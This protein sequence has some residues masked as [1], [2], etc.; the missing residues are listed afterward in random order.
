M[1]HKG[2]KKKGPDMLDTSN[3]PDKA[4]QFDLLALLEAGA[5]FGHQKAKWSPK[6]AQFIY[7]EKDGVHIFDLEK[8]A[9]Q[10]RTA[11]NLAYQMGKQ[12]KVMVIVGT[13]RQAQEIVR[14]VATANKVM[15]ITSRWLGGLLTNWEQVKGSIKRMNEI[16]TGLA[17][18]A[19]KGYTKYEKVQLE[20]EMNRLNRF[21]GGIKDLKGKPDCIF[22]IDPKREKNA[23]KEANIMGVPVIAMIDSNADPDLVD[24]PIP[25]NDDAIKSIEM[26]VT[27]VVAGYEAGKK[28]K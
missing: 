7:M 23:V 17:T 16:E 14:E 19:F 26:V 21:F 18:D 12:G 27:A 22:V 15:H 13:K 10:L 1:S 3:L 6:M 24:L 11:Y 9:A 28:D 2:E 25:A 20:K 5:H 4:P 8:T